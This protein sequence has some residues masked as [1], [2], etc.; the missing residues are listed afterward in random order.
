MHPMDV[1]VKDI[2]W[3]K[4]QEHS[5]QYLNEKREQIDKKIKKLKAILPPINMLEQYASILPGLESPNFDSNDLLEP[6]N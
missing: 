2:A 3:Q 4:R 6:I 5:I 1:R